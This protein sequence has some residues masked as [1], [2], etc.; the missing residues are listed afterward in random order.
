MC[1]LSNA[2]SWVLHRSWTGQ[3]LVV[4]LIPA[5]TVVSASGV[6][7]VKTIVDIPFLS[8]GSFRCDKCCQYAMCIII[9]CDG[10]TSNKG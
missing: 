9:Q 2:V 6:I 3:F 10:L 1:V 8:F 5:Y 4:S 7:R